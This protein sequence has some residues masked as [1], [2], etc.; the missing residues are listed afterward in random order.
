[1]YDED[2]DKKKRDKVRTQQ[3]LQIPVGFQRAFSIAN[4]ISR[5]CKEL[6][7]VFICL[8]CVWSCLVSKLCSEVLGWVTW[9]T[10]L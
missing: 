5:F 2:K 1:M 3:K 10:S 8:Y 7:D 6:F 4:I 9:E